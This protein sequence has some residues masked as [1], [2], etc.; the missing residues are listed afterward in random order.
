MDPNKC[1]TDYVG[2][3]ESILDSALRASL[4]LSKVR[5]RGATKFVAPI[6]RREQTLSLFAT[7]P[8]HPG[9]FVA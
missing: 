7:A 1:E 5:A 9:D 2:L 6:R 3:A 4:R 8:P